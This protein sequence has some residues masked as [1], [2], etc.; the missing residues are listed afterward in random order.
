[1]TARFGIGS[2]LATSVRIW[3]RNLVRFIVITALLYL[4]VI[5]W[6]L[7]VVADAFGIFSRY[8]RFVFDLNPMLRVLPS[9]LFVVHAC[10]T[11]AVTQGALVALN[12]KPAPIG[13]SLAVAVRRFIPVVG[14]ALVVQVVTL[15]VFV[16]LIWLVS[17]LGDRDPAIVGALVCYIA[18]LSVFYLV[19]PVAAVERRAII[20][21]IVRGLRLARGGRLRVFALVLLGQVVYWGGRQLLSIILLSKLAAASGAYRAVTL[22]G[23]IIL[24]L[25]LVLFS[26]GAVIA[27][28]TYRFL[29]EDKEGPAADQLVQVF[30]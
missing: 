25:H 30:E 10:T 5:A 24:G 4:P 20:G 17:W 1:M 11:A 18:M 26:L 6:D 13:R 28:V 8:Y 16:G 12:G 21:S 22:Y 7:A 27:A 29:R 9:G 2:V 23:Y 15:G 14:V 3:A 19:I